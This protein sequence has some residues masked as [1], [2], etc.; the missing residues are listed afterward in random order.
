MPRLALCDRTVSLSE[1]DYFLLPD[2]VK[3]FQS[4]TLDCLKIPKHKRLSSKKFRHIKAK[5]LIVT[6]HPVV[7]SVRNIKE[8]HNI[9][10]WI[11][12]WLRNAFLNKNIQT[13]KKNKVYI[14]RSETT[15][16]FRPSRFI[17]NEEEIKKYLLENKL[18][19][20]TVQV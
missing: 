15:N 14:D 5:K 10:A 9:P 6:D 2:D 18:L 13:G 11:I 3:K 17:S 16:N 7:T 19:V 20:F 8:T 1:I 4:E 12:I